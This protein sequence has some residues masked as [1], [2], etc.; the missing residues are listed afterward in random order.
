MLEGDDDF[1][2]DAV[3]GEFGDLSAKGIIDPAKVVRSAL[4]NAASV[5]GML[6]TASCAIAE[7]GPD[8]VMEHDAAT[9]VTR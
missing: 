4:L 6:L 1:G 7:A 5:A 9:G 3:T 8:E 2:F